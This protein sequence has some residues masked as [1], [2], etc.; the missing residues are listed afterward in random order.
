MHP[1]HKSGGPKSAKKSLAV[2]PGV[3]TSAEFGSLFSIAV[4]R[5]SKACTSAVF[6]VLAR[7]CLTQPN[8]FFACCSSAEFLAHLIVISA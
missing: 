6:W 8:Y 7:S 3:G 2:Q 5:S 1:R 4:R